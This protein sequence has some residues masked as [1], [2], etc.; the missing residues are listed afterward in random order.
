MPMLLDLYI[1]IQNLL[2]HPPSPPPP[3]QSPTPTKKNHLQV[4]TNRRTFTTTTTTLLSF[5]LLG[6]PPFLSTSTAEVGEDPKRFTLEGYTDI[7]HGFTLLR[8][9]LYVKLE[10]KIWVTFIAGLL[11]GTSFT[12][13]VPTKGWS[14]NP[15]AG[16]G[17]DLREAPAV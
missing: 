14:S 1:S 13:K 11:L 8:P 17:P 4:I 16:E 12:R 3:S 9:C 2:P 10:T 5:L 6:S 15:T 7:E